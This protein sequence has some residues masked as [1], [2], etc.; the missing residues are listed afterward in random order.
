MPPEEIR[1]SLKN[2]PFSPFRIRLSDGRTFD[3]TNPELVMPGR[4]LVVIGIK[5]PADSDPRPLIQS[6]VTVTLLHVVSLEPIPAAAQQ[7]G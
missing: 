5:D 1:N 4:H 7:A 3:V 2:R 6:S